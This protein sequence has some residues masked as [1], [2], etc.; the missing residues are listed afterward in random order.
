MNVPGGSGEPDGGEV[1]GAVGVGGVTAKLKRPL[2]TDNKLKL[3]LL[4]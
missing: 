4:C 3:T 1:L 2:F